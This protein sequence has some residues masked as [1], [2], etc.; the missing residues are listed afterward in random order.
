MVANARHYTL[1]LCVAVF[2]ISVWGGATESSCTA[3]IALCSQSCIQQ[4]NSDPACVRACSLAYTSCRS[5]ATAPM[6]VLRPTDPTPVTSTRALRATCAT[7]RKACQHRC[8]MRLVGRIVCARKCTLD[9]SACR[10]H[11][12]AQLNRY[13]SASRPVGAPTT[14]PIP[15]PIRPAFV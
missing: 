11:A 9:H 13:R 8:A 6:P 14:R 10:V 1:C 12:D 7:T 15:R 4:R 5:L 2:A 3:E